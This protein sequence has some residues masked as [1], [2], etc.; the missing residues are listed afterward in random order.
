MN[1]LVGPPVATHYGRRSVAASLGRTALVSRGFRNGVGLMV[2]AEGI[3]EW[4]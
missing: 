4:E 2:G 3:G 1:A